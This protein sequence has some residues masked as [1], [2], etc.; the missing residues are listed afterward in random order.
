M[1]IEDD[2]D[3]LGLTNGSV[4]NPFQSSNR[5]PK[6]TSGVT[7]I[8]TDNEN[9]ESI[10]IGEPFSNHQTFLGSNAFNQ[11]R[12]KIYTTGNSRKILT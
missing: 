4:G 8:A 7:E 6:K 12:A 9:L 5:K 3:I 1:Q 2:L 11:D 10:K